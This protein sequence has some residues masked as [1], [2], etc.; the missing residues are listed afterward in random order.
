MRQISR[1]VRSPLRIKICG[2]TSVADA[3]V[4]VEA[5]ADAIGLNFWPGSKRRCGLDAARA[6]GAAV[7]ERARLVGVFVD[8]D[9]AEIERTLGASGLRWA[10]LHGN[11]LPALVEALSPHVFKALHVRDEG[12]LEAALGVPGQ[13]LLVDASLPGMPGGT[14][15]TCDWR[16]A[17]RLAS[18]RRVWLAGGLDPSNVAEAI[19]EVRPF[20]VDVA[21]GVERAP[22]VKDHERIRAFIDAARGA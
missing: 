16:L 1:A 3:M 15:R 20:G 4:C 17:A 21:S 12:E 8:A 5:G 13:E 9:R 7:G 10:Q 19:A 18:A 14:G 22:G 6:I 2:V 11:E